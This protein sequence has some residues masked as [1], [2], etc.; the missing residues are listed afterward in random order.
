MVYCVSLLLILIVPPLVASLLVYPNRLRKPEGFPALLANL[1]PGYFYISHAGNRNAH[2]L[3]WVALG[4][5]ALALFLVCLY[6]LRRWFR[7]Q[8]AIVADKLKSMGVG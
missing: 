5:F 1:S 8:Q 4:A 2:P 7:W 6:L 3:G